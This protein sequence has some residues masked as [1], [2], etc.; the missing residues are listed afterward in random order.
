MTLG[1]GGAVGSNAGDAVCPPA[2]GVEG[3]SLGVPRPA[4]SRAE[5]TIEAARAALLPTGPT[6]RLRGLL[7][8]LLLL[9]PL[10]L[11][12]PLP[13][14]LLLLLLLLLLPLLLAPF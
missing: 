14:P 9:L 1:R 5:P 12:L 11:P 4:A 7:T 3:S 8:L 10:L 6:L 2:G 13:L